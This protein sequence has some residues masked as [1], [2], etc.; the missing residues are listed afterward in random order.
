[1]GDLTPKSRLRGVAVTMLL[2]GRTFGST[3]FDPAGGG[4]VLFV[5][6]FWSFGHPAVT[7]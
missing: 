7:S 3:F 5:Y 4:P 2:A 6:P 1:M